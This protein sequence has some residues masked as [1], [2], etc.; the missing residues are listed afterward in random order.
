MPYVAMVTS[1]FLLSSAHKPVNSAKVNWCRRLQ[2]LVVSGKL[3]C[4]SVSRYLACIP[5]KISTPIEKTEELTI[6]IIDGANN[7][8]SSAN[9]GLMA[10]HFTDSSFRCFSQNAHEVTFRTTLLETEQFSIMEL[11]NAILQWIDSGAV[12]SVSGVLLTIDPQCEVVIESIADP[13]CT[14]NG[15]QSHTTTTSLP[16]SKEATV[17]ITVSTASIPEGT[18]MLTIKLWIVPSIIINSP[19]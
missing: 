14:S 13:E 16:V 3:I 1:C 2:C 4:F 10:N 9:C 19:L 8:C 12:T 6:A 11:I 15:T 17:H 18:C 7:L 5:I